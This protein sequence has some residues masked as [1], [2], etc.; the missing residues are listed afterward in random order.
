MEERFLFV[1][2]ETCFAAE[3]VGWEL[4]RV[5]SVSTSRVGV[6]KFICKCVNDFVAGWLAVLSSGVL[7]VYTAGSASLGREYMLGE[8]VV[9]DDID[10]SLRVIPDMSGSC[11]DADPSSAANT[12]SLPTNIPFLPAFISSAPANIPFFP[13]NTSSL[14]S[15]PTSEL[16]AS[17]AATSFPPTRERI[18]QVD[19][20]DGL[21]ALITKKIKESSDTHQQEIDH[22]QETVHQQQEI[23]SEQSTQFLDAQKTIMEQ[24]GK[25]DDLELLISRSSCSQQQELQHLQEVVQQQ[26]GVIPEQSKKFLDSQGKIMLQREEIDELKIERKDLERRLNMIKQHIGEA[27]MEW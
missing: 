9:S 11:R 19:E 1:R 17:F 10:V 2:M 27:I 13:A 16:A 8:E 22:M 18:L 7:A 24:Q 3:M 15:H 14:A 6:G 25:I 21:E 5:A 23:I 26:Q 4:S 20:I 12:P